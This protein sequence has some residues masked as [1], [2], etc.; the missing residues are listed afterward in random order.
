MEA[1]SVLSDCRKAG[2]PDE[3]RRNSVGSDQRAP[4]TKYESDIS[5]R[6]GGGMWHPS[7]TPSQWQFRGS[8]LSELRQAAPIR[9]EKLKNASNSRDKLST[10]RRTVLISYGTLV[11]P[12]SIASK[13]AA[14]PATTP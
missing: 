7:K 3:S 5:G 11:L 14:V 9:S 4:T 2:V 13:T 1:C 6:L 8:S 10:A 12:G